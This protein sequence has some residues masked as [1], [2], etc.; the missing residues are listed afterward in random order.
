M[1]VCACVCVCVCY[2]EPEWWTTC[3][4]PQGMFRHYFEPPYG[5][6]QKKS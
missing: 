3:P 1:C 2:G 6:Q 4:C 5:V